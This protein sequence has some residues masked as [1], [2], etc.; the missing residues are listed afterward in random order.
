VG[1]EFEFLSIQQF[2]DGEDL[3]AG[4]A[5]RKVFSLVKACGRSFR[6]HGLGGLPQRD[7]RA[8]GGLLAL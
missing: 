4:I 2:G 7:K 8:D 6:G 3:Q 1:G 5:A